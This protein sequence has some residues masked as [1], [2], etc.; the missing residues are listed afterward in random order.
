MFEFLAPRKPARPENASNR[1]DG[2]RYATQNLR[3]QFGQVLDLSVSGIRVHASAKPACKAG[4]ILQLTISSGKERVAMLA[5]VVRV[6]KKT[7]GYETAMRFVDRSPAS[8]RAI[9]NLAKFGFVMGAQPPKAT[10]SPA[11]PEARPASAAPR[12]GNYPSPFAATPKPRPAPEAPAPLRVVGSLPDYYGELG[13][14][15]SASE[16]EIATSFRALAMKHHPDHNADPETERVM[17]RINLAYRTLS[18]A[19][20]RREYDRLLAKTA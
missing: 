4:D 7:G 6:M 13:L 12:P 8:E 11:A 9:S 2:D 15:P 5:R 10:P 20:K 1:R 16:T 19:E 3:C 18:N 14:T 17:S